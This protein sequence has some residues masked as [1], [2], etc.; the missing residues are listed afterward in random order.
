MLSRRRGR[1]SVLSSSSRV[2][3]VS[4]GVAPPDPM[5]VQS[6]QRS[7]TDT[8]PAG[9]R[10]DASRASR[11]S[12]SI[13]R[14]ESAFMRSGTGSRA[15]V[16]RKGWRSVWCASPHATRAFF[17][18]PSEQPPELRPTQCDAQPCGLEETNLQPSQQTSNGNKIRWRGHLEQGVRDGS[19]FG[20]E[21]CSAPPLPVLVD[22][23]GPSRLMLVTCW[24]HRRCAVTLDW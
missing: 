14:W 22:T 13:K 12:S 20:T 17:V 7:S 2:L 18:R 11:R 24:A 1:R 6:A 10:S 15:D 23:Y 21:A 5:R 3:T 4:S 19:W 9:Q 8:R 16:R